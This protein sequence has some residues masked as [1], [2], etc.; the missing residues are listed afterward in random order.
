[1]KLKKKI[2]LILDKYDLSVQIPDGFDTVYDFIRH[3]GHV[4]PYESDLFCYEMHDLWFVS[5][6]RDNI[7]KGYYG[8][9]IGR[10]TPKNWLL[11]ID[12]ILEELLRFDSDL[13]IYQIKLKFGSIRF[14]VESD[15]IE[16][17]F[18]IEMLI[19]DKMFSNKLIY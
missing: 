1:M 11:A 16:D 13:Y 17:M 19:A 5:K 4:E 2:E 14:Y 15:V 9:A 18:E 6:Y 7:V 3:H 12:E 10:P 8:F